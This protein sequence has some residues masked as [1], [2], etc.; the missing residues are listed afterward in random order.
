MFAVETPLATTTALR[1]LPAHCQ[2]W[3]VMLYLNSELLNYANP[4]TSA[5][6]YTAAGGL[7]FQPGHAHSTNHALRLI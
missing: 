2:L 6:G 1:S 4:A 7:S 5:A 3:F